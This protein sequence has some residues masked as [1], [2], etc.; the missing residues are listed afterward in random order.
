M[1]KNSRK[2]YFVSSNEILKLSSFTW[3]VLLTLPR[4]EKMSPS[5]AIAYMHL[6]NENSDPRSVVVIPHN[7]PS[8]TRYFTQCSPTAEK[9]SGN[10]AVGLMVQY[11]TIRV[12]AP[13]TRI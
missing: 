4:N 10:A 9:A 6:G 1:N 2:V 3:V 11:G 8:E 7:A 5:A 12:K 13:P